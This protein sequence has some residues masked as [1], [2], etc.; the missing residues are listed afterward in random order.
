MKLFKYEISAFV[1]GNPAAVDGWSADTDED[2][3]RIVA[4]CAR[5]EA[6][7]G[8]VRILL[9]GSLGANAIDDDYLGVAPK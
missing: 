7:I 4:N 8:E 5:R 9:N 6:G 2:M 1:A 3:A